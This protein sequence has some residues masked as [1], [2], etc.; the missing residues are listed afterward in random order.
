MNLPFERIGGLIL[1]AFSVCYATLSVDIPLLAGQADQFNP[2]TMPQALAAIGVLIAMGLIFTPVSGKQAWPR[3][4]WLR[5]GSFLV[6]MSAYGLL[7]KP[8]GFIPATLAFLLIGF[9]VLG[10]RR[11]LVLALTAFLITGCFWAL[12]WWGL[13]VHLPPWPAGVANA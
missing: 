10:E 6:L 3:M 11:P 1:L 8:A 12:M 7:L 13:G 2:R 9:T 5:G 4:N